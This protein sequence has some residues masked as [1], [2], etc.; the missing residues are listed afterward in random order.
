MGFVSFIT[1]RTHPDAGEEGR[2]RPRSSP[3]TRRGRLLALPLA[4]ILAVTASGPLGQARQALATAP[5]S[6]LTSPKALVYVR[7]PYPER[8]YTANADGSGAA[9]LFS[10]LGD[11]SQFSP[12]AAGATVAYEDS[13][14]SGTAIYASS[15]GVVRL[16][17]SN[18]KGDAGA[19]ALSPAGDELAYTPARKPT[20]LFAGGVDGPGREIDLSS[21][22]ITS[23]SAVSFL[24][25]GQLL[26][27]GAA[28]A[29]PD[30]SVW[31][32]DLANGS[33]ED[34]GVLPRGSVD[35][36]AGSP[37]GERI[38]VGLV[39]LASSPAY[40]EELLLLTRDGS[41]WDVAGL[42]PARSPD[43]SVFDD[44]ASFS[45]DGRSL[46]FLSDRGDPAR[47]VVNLY[48]AKLASPAR[49]LDVSRENVRADRAAEV[50]GVDD[51]SWSPGSSAL[52]FSSARATRGTGLDELFSVPASG[53]RARRLTHASPAAGAN[54]PLWR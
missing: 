37:D 6:L 36:I 45:P 13:T 5:P 25:E 34:V 11:D 30:G 39:P 8:I 49:V 40:A 20:R 41:S 43:D 17:S 16:I 1:P 54:W 50:D 2:P 18:I 28:K 44:S 9:A 38:A 32:V 35:S 46:A 29:H 4:A 47:G 14:A 31:V 27:A 48:V 23:I 22:Q 42:T 52:V 12:Q 33:V 21:A 7:G 26:V 53:G 24:G 19:F 51:F 3:L 15:G 10:R